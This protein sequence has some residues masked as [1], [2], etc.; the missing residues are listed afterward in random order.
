LAGKISTQMRHKNGRGE[1]GSEQAAC[2]SLTEESSYQNRDP[3]PL[4]SSIRPAIM[5]TADFEQDLKSIL[6]D[7]RPIL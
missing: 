3:K 6:L 1:A 4:F 5:E 2:R 7:V